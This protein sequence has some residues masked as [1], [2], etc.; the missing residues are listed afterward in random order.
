MISVIVI[1]KDEGERLT[2]CFESLQVIHYLKHELIYVDSGSVDDSVQRAL[3]ANASVYLLSETHP[4]PGLGR[5]IGA[6]QAKGEWLLFLDGDMRLQK[7]FVEKALNIVYEKKAEAVA[8]IRDDEYIAGNTIH[9][10][11]QNYFNCTCERNC[12]EFGGALFISAEVLKS[13]GG[14]SGDTIA[15]EEAELHA[16]LNSENHPV[17]EIPVPMIIHSDTVRDNR[18]AL[19]ILFSMRRLGEG[20][21]FR[22]AMANHH[23]KAYVQRESVKFGF[24]LLDWLTVL[25]LFLPYGI[26]LLS[27][28]LFQ[29]FQLGYYFSK[30]KLRSFI[31]QKLFF[32]AFPLGLLTYK[33]RSEAF[34][35]VKV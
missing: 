1:G 3:A 32:F 24:Y 5:R 14:W 17:L 10:Q 18:S 22:C 27:L 16:R 29:C 23:A 13:C 21:A 35:E 31:G 7:G 20:Q 25:F 9:S 2:R 11:I 19:S 6:S 28:S 8:G 4:T 30:K 26:G 12:P 33:K 34:K 15:C